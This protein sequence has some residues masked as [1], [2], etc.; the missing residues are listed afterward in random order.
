M[1]QNPKVAI[2]MTTYNSSRYVL[3]QLE[4][5]F[6]QTYKNWHLYITD[7]AST[8]NTVE[9]INQVMMSRKTDIS[10][11][12]NKENVGSGLNF[13][14]GL[15]MINDEKYIAVCDSDDIWLPKKLKIQ[16]DFLEN[17]PFVLVH[18]DAELVN[19]NLV[20]FNQTIWSKLQRDTIK[21]EQLLEPKF[22][23]LIE[24]NYISGA[25]ILFKKNLVDRIVPYPTKMVQ[26][27]WI[28]LVASLSGRIAGLDTSLI[29]YRQHQGNLQGA[30][31]RTSRYYFKHLFSRSFNKS[32]ITETKQ[33]IK[34]LD[35][36]SKLN[37]GKDFGLLIE[38]RKK[39]YEIVYSLLTSIGIRRRVRALTQSLYVL[40][41]IE[42]SYFRKIILF[43]IIN[44]T[45][46]V[47]N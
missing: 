20:P 19:E 7:D 39:Q 35:R 40:F 6:L 22:S 38:Q 9:L 24:K 23:T 43:F 17:N 36:L 5:I 18:H 16:T 1:K 14:R 32:Y 42:S 3:E 33:N 2:I 29:L 46:P 27:Y 10:L 41:S 13:E 34:M 4:S 28:A 47:R 15:K 12:T 8:D 25:T 26:D 31:A 44:S 45:F 30:T 37:N 11:K 21:R